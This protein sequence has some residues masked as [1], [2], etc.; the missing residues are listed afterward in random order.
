ML[1]DFHSHFLPK[2]DD[3]SRSID[4]SLQIL[5]IMAKGG[6]DT[7]VATPHFYCTEQSVES[8]LENR[9]K[10]Y[11]ELKPNLRPEH[12]DIHFGAEVLYDHSL[13]NY[14]KLPQLCIEGTNWLLLEM[15]YTDLDDKIINGVASI[16]ERGDV[17]VFIAHI[18]R[19]LNFTSMKR[20]EQLMRLEV[21]GQINA[22][23]L[24]SFM[25]K[26]RCMKLIEHGYVHVLGSDYHRIGRGDVTVDIGYNIITGNKKF[27]DFAEYAENN[28]RKILADEP[29][30]SII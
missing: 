24:T 18:E 2:I 30:G 6:I 17:K 16:T 10:A 23:S 25:S 12:P 27:D 11:E 14:E 5:D 22:K 7:I 9:T 13:V 4:E 15:P 29:L 8:F 19:Y 26:R 28:G 21:L 20:L 3:G 1:I